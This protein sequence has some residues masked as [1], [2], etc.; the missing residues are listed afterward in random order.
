MAPIMAGT[1]TGTQEIKD[2][3]PSSYRSKLPSLSPGLIPSRLYNTA[4]MRRNK[5]YYLRAPTRMATLAEAF[6]T[7]AEDV[8]D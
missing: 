2:C 5:M 4:G 8:F 3:E 1:Q 7:R 6:R